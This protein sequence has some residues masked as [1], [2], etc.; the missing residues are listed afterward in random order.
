MP[1]LRSWLKEPHVRGWWGDPEE[2]LR[3]I[4]DMVEGSDTTRPFLILLD[5]A[6]VGYIQYWFMGHPRNE[7]KDH[8]WLLGLA[9]R[10]AVGVDLSIGDADKLSGRES[11]PR[12]LMRFVAG[13]SLEGLPRAI[14]I[15]PDPANA[16]ACAPMT[17]PGSGRPSTP[18]PNR[19]R[20][21]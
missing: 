16:Q 8:P 18:R 19:Q 21:C 5:G 9:V 3:H 14:I 10:D 1:L 15:D 7:A 11:A 6:A 2:E 17:R 4:R 13:S 20:R 12:R